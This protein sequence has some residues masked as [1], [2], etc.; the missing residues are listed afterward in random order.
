[1]K[2]NEKLEQIVKHPDVSRAM[3]GS[4]K[5]A[6]LRTP[7][8]AEVLKLREAI[9]NVKRARMNAREEFPHVRRNTAYDDG[10]I[11][12]VPDM[13]DGTRNLAK[14]LELGGLPAELEQM[15]RAYLAEPA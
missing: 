2:T 12:Q 13:P 7:G 15:I 14:A 6:H 4:P 9:R 1:M 5:W 10:F 3:S 11:V 8:M